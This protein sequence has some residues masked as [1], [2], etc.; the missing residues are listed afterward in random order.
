MDAAPQAVALRERQLQP[1]M[2][3][4]LGSATMRARHRRRFFPRLGDLL[5]RVGRLGG[6]PEAAPFAPGSPRRPV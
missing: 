3:R 5:A 4:N 1:R 6:A 2:V